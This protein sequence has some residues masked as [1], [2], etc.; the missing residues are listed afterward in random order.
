MKPG[1]FTELAENYARYR[2]GYSQPVV[3]ALMALLDKP[4]DQCCAV[5]VGAGTGV[6]T[7]MLGASPWKKLSAVEPNESMRNWGEKQTPNVTWSEGSGE[8][9]GL[10]DQSVDWVSMASSF[11]WTRFDDALAEF[12]RI[13]KP[14]G[15]FVAIWNP[16][17]IEA[18]PLLVEIENY[19]KTLVPELQRVS[20][21]RS[22]LASELSER[23]SKLQGWGELVHIE[24]F[25]I[26]NQTQEH[27]LGLWRSVNDIQAQAGPERFGQFLDW[28]QNKIAGLEH[29]QATYQTRAW[30]IQ[31]LS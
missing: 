13:L 5:D 15:R 8:S 16:R 7:R 20:S 29:I 14:G 30:S 2:P 10:A 19:L 27:Y 22:G 17:F 24:G 23:F 25:H 31:K 26:E 4:I 6:F 12:H 9:T 21:G 28:V 1:V 18:N 11:H 3:R